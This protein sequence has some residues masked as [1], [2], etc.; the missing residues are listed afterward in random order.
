MRKLHS[1][2]IALYD[3]RPN[4]RIVYDGLLLPEREARSEVLSYPPLAGGG[5]RITPPKELSK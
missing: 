3:T 5:G 2:C 4:Q 1:C